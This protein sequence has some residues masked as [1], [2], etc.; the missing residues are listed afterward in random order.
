ME[1]ITSGNKVLVLFCFLKTMFVF[2]HQE[3]DFQSSLN[4]FEC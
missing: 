2:G 1:A 4:A 3:L